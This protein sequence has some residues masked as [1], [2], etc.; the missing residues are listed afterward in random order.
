[1]PTI[2]YFEIPADDVG[3]AK[4]F[5]SELFD[6]EIEPMEIEG[7]DY[8]RIR[9]KDQ[10]GDPG[11]NGGMLKRKREGQPIM[12]HVTVSL[13]DE[14]LARAQELGAKVV[15]D[16]AHIKGKGYIAIFEDTEGNQMALWEVEK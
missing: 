6:W 11:I 14:S 12:T 13:I 5:Y 1:M 7:M 10:A 2:E 4:K 3:R 9:T 8:W 15:V 16:K